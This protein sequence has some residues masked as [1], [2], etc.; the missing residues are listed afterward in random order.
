MTH[1]ILVAVDDPNMRMSMEF[2]FRR[3]GFDVSVAPDGNAALAA[4]AAHPPDLVLLDL[5]GA[6]RSSTDVCEALRAQDGLATL[7]VVLLSAK[8]RDSDIAKGLALG[9][10]TFLT[11]PCSTQD[12]LQQV[13]TL[14]EVPA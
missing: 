3:H 8:C 9:A 14:L 13:R 2:M 11:K 5:N 4:V 6:G 10:D 12:L 1:R 7:R